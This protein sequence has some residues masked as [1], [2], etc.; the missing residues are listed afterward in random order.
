MLFVLKRPPR[1][2][3]AVWSVRTDRF[4]DLADQLFSELMLTGCHAI[5]SDPFA[6]VRL[7]SP[8]N[9]RR[10]ASLTC[11][12]V[13]SLNAMGPPPLGDQR[14]SGAS[15]RPAKVYPQG[16]PITGNGG[17]PMQLAKLVAWWSHLN[18]K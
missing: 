18:G 5:D 9:Q 6:I 13:T 11:T 7:P 1:L 2:N 12:T 17:G 8:L 16:G 15:L 10:S 4:Y 3:V 14:P